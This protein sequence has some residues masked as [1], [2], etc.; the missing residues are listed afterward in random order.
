VNPTG[1]TYKFTVTAAGAENGPWVFNAALPLSTPD[2]T[3]DITQLA[4][5]QSLPGNTSAFVTLSDFNA[6]VA[7]VA[8]LE[9]LAGFGGTIDGGTP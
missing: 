9:A 4:P 3:I 6:L 5:V 8:A 7:R 2:G 1:F